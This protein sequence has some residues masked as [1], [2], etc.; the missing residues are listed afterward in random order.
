MT[1]ARLRLLHVADHYRTDL[2]DVVRDF[3]QPCL[4]AAVQYDRAVGYF[5]GD[6]LRIVARG[7]DIF[8]RGGGHIRLV[9]SPHLNESDIEQIRA[10]YELREVVGGA[11]ARELDPAKSRSANELAALG[12]LG[13]LV[14]EG[15]LDIKIAIVHTNSGMSM[16]HE[17]I[18]VFVDQDDDV[19][20]FNGSMNETTPA[21]LANFESVEVFAS[22]RDADRARSAR[23]RRDFEDLWHD[24]SR[25][26][27]VMSFP[28][29]AR[30]RLLAI[31][32]IKTPVTPDVRRPDSRR[33]ATQ[34][35]RT[36][37]DLELR[38]YQKRAVDSW[39]LAGGRGILQMATGTGKTVTALAALDQLARQLR[40]KSIP[41]LT[42]VVV[43]LLDLVEQWSDEFTRFGVTPIKCRDSSHTWEPVVRDIVTL[44]REGKVETA[45]L[46]VTNS[47]FGKA[48]F[49]RVLADMHTHMLL[50]ADE[51]HHLGAQNLRTLLPNGAQFRLGLSATP[52]RWFDPDGTD[53]LTDYFG[54]VLVKLD[55]ADAI[56]IGA[57]T[58]YRYTPVLVS[59]APEENQYYAELTARIGAFLGDAHIDAVSPDNNTELGSLLRRRSQI[60]GHA[61]GKVPALKRELERRQN[62]WYQLVYCA[63]GAPPSYDGPIKARQIDVVLD[64]VGNTM[65]LAAHTF[66]ARED[67]RVRSRLLQ[68][69]GSGD[70][71]RLL[72]SMR[73]LDEGVDVP[74]A[75][76]AYMLASSSNPRQFVQRRGRILRRAPGKEIAEIVDFV[77]VPQQND[78]LFK[79]ERGLFRRELGRCLEFARNSENFGQA[80]ATLRPL[81]EYYGLVDMKGSLGDE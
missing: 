28:E 36:P 14:A 10:G 77:A 52:E 60:L 8:R 31:A 16:Y 12:L 26:V 33:S 2:D 80:L 34:W 62:S 38:D 11:V 47:T 81:R 69:F 17:K 79:A 58:P 53:A 76:I 74:D 1:P 50:I 63:E 44:L 4:A 23:I 3:Y 66:T 43:P 67:K 72:V 48:A 40:Q 37:R 25:N 73:C 30:N 64:L 45:T 46:V 59:L 32:G 39:L 27:E 5:T 71:L 21:L 18:G 70:D 54:G 41:L 65:G 7:L 22:W 51:A 68:R 9:A 24:R 13:Q 19:V 55:L 49:Q 78:S 15:C 75:R 35:A 20:A 29:A 56:R 61:T 6:T 42:V 57:L